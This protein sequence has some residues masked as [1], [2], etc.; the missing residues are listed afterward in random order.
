MFLRRVR[1]RLLA[2]RFLHHFTSALL[3]ASSAAVAVIAVDRWLVPGLWRWEWSVTLGSSAF[4]LALAWTFWRSGLSLFQTAIRADQQ[5]N[6]KE[7]VSSACYAQGQ[8]SQ[9][10]SDRPDAVLAGWESLVVDDAQQVLEDVTVRTSFPVRSPRHAL[11]LPLP[12]LICV[13]LLLWAPTYDPFGLQA[14]QEEKQA[15]EKA[16]EDRE[17]NL[18]KQIEDLRSKLDDTISKEAQDLLKQVAAARDAKKPP[19][20][21]SSDANPDKAKGA[22]PEP[23][24]PQKD[25]MV[26]VARR[27]ELLKKGLNGE[28]YESLKKALKELKGLRVKSSQETQGLRASLKAGNLAK[29][30]EELS[31]LQKTIQELTD[32]KPS[33]LTADEKKK[34]DKLQQ[35]LAALSKEAASL[36]KMS[37]GLS[38]MSGMS[39][40]NMKKLLQDM[41]QLGQDLNSL[42]QLSDEMALLKDALNMLELS[43]QQ[44]ANLHNCQNCGKKLSK[45]GGT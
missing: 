30:K 4:V 5:L 40:A 39:S 11:W 8:Y 17:K 2:N 33:E 43:K 22:K 14:A 26:D 27:E 36:S 23:R 10:G 38:A 6:L 1:R 3:M 18:Q 21:N 24:D 9:V 12:L 13:A 37:P 19:N 45:P 28:K 16:I 20:E 31:K 7:R 34:L 35:E 29:A 41:G 42:N 15:L 32:K 44:L 25:A